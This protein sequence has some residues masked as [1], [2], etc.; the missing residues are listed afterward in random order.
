MPQK[1]KGNIQITEIDSREI[2][3]KEIDTKISYRLSEVDGTYFISINA[4]NENVAV[5]VG[6]SERYARKIFF[7]FINGEVTPCTAEDIIRDFMS[8]KIG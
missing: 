3:I 5:S 7:Q 4:E 1:S 2:H 8:D 6:S